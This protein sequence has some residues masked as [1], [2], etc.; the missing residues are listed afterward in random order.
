MTDQRSGPLSIPAF[1]AIWL[2]SLPGNAAL[3]ILGVGASWE[4]TG[5]TTSPQLVATVQT[6]LLLPVMLLSMAAGAAADMYDRRIVA[7]AALTVATIGA[8]VLAAITAAGLLTPTTLLA[9][10]FLIGCSVALYG[11]SWQASAAEQVPADLATPAIAMNSISYNIARSIGPAVGGVIVAVA[12]PLAAFAACAILYLPLIAAFWAWRRVREPSRLPP[13]RLG[14]AIGA[15]LRYI[16]HAPPVRALLFRLFLTGLMAGSLSGLL[17]LVSR[18]SLGGGAGVYGLMLGTIGVGALVGGVAAGRLRAQFPNEW[19]VRG[20]TAV[21]GAAYVVIAASHSIWIT[22]LAMFVMGAAWMVL[23]TIVTIGVQLLVPRWVAG[24]ALAGYQSAIMGG[25]A[26]GSWSWGQIAGVIGIAETMTV[27]G[28]AVILAVLLGRW[29]PMPSESTVE[30]GNELEKPSMSLALTAR[31]GPVVIEIEY[32]VTPANARAF[33][34]AMQQTRLIRKRNGAYDWSISRDVAAP[35]V[36][37]ERY[38][39]S[40]WG[41]YLRQRDRRTADEEAFERDL[42]ERLCTS[43]DIRVRRWLERPFGSVRWKDDTPDRG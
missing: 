11:P 14:S 18:D 24:R 5:L 41:D 9:G 29:L 8:V 16:I 32:E 15:G 34:T 3:L 31:S 19:L 42:I 22:G 39:Y 1:R 38:H 4:M 35:H 10:C 6:M 2:A 23:V 27:S 21:T 7:L 40:T 26:L 25:L 13:E 33:Y 37:L 17:P 43:Q 30:Q 20:G 28:I 12:G 36:W